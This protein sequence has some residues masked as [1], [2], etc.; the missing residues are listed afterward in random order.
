MKKLLLIS[1]RKVIPSLPRFAARQIQDSLEPP[2]TKF[3]H[4][5]RVGVALDNRK[6]P[7]RGTPSVNL[8]EGQCRNEA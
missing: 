6:L 5:T 2:N 1:S 4:W 8:M 7:Q 3:E